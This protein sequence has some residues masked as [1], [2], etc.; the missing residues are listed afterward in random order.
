MSY[1]LKALFFASILISSAWVMPFTSAQN[2]TM[3][4][5][6]FAQ[7]NL[8]ISF[9]AIECNQGLVL[10]VKA[11]HNS[12]ACVKPQT[13][14]SLVERGWGLSKEQM[15]WVEFDPVQCK[16]TPWD[17]YDQQLNGNSTRVPIAHSEFG[18]IKQYFK[19]H[20]IIILESKKTGPSSYSKSFAPTCNSNSDTVF[21][22][23]VSE[24]DVDKIINLG[25][26][27]LK[28]PLPSNAYWIH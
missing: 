8:G 20:G 2:A 15:I 13:A 11:S 16:V 21:Y 17:E 23:L 26:K 3:T 27:I 25:Y 18:I 7:F 14:S 9:D 4:L 28:T 10:I 1:A 5:S 6:P 22:F 24:L 19:E 12:P